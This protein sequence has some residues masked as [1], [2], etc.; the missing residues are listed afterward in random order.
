MDL[1]DYNKKDTEEKDE[2][3]HMEL[4]MACVGKDVG[5]FEEVNMG[6]FDIL[7]YSCMKFSRIMKFYNKDVLF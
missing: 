2:N 7:L 1:I 5:E 3:N 6:V 4:Q